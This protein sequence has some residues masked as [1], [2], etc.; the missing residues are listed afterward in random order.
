MM[1]GVS[2]WEACVR[3]RMGGF[4]VRG[5]PLESIMLD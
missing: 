2:L 1:A 3:M 5:D 4:W